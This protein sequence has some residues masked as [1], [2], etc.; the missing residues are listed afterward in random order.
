MIYFLDLF[1]TAVFAV[2][3]A[4]A[5]GRKRMDLF[6]VVVLASVTALGGGTLRDLSLGCHPLFWISDRTYVFLAAATSLATF[7]LARYRTEPPKRL[8][9]LSDALGLAVFTVIGA[10]K[11]LDL[12]APATV[13]V[14]MGIMTGVVGGMMRDVLSGEIPLI[15]RREVY[16]TASLCG[17]TVFVGLAPVLASSPLRSALAVAATL[18]LRL[19][20]IRWNLSLP[21]YPSNGKDPE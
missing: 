5:A 21:L 12:Q 4:L 10:Q 18:S 13:A 16:A 1:G 7:V 8:L 6:G 3:G 20:A 19:A 2:S 11:A 15:L 9:L 14:I 17:A